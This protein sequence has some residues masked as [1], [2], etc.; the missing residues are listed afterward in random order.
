MRHLD[1]GTLRRMVDEPLSLSSQ[2][3]R[4][5]A[6]CS[7]C[8]ARRAAIEADARAVESAVARPRPLTGDAQATYVKVMHAAAS[9]SPSARPK[10]TQ[11]FE[12]FFRWRMG[13]AATPIIA[14]A[15]AA[16]AVLMLLF[17]PVGTVAQNFLTIFEPRQFVA[18]PVSK[19]EFQYMPDLQSFGTIVEHPTL[20]SR[21][22]IVPGREVSSAAQAFAL[23]G[24]RV[25]QPAWLPAS[26]PH[27]VRYGVA[28]RTTASFTFSAAKARSYAAGAHR[29]MPAMPPGLDGST[30]TLQVGP[31]VMIGYGTMP[32]DQHAVGGPR[33]RHRHDD[34]NFDLPPLVIV[35]GFAPQVRSTGATAREIEGYLLQMPG[36]PAQLADAIRAIG[37]PTTTMPIPVPVDKAFSQNVTV[38]GVSGLAIGDDTGVGG[39][40]VWQKNGIVYGVGGALRQRDLME[41]ARSLR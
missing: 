39:M 4:H 25:R 37:D 10:A 3:Q 29:P 14:A 16:A 20:D 40:I 12:D 41:I 15:L 9:A 34:G 35:E 27:A 6:D 18:I 17:T 26:V 24:L 31:M 30:L 28:P 8:R 13:T 38:D 5:Y 19:G 36:V 7:S 33:S 11:R 22:R 23:T 2:A 21:G 1:D 32:I